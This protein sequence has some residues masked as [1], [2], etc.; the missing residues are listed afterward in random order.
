M[1]HKEEGRKPA[2]GALRQGGAGASFLWGC[3]A[4]GGRW[5]GVPPMRGGA[6]CAGSAARY[7]Y[8]PSTSEYKNK[9]HPSPHTGTCQKKDRFPRKNKILKLWV[10]RCGSKSTSSLTIG[11]RA[12]R[13]KTQ[14]PQYKRSATAGRFFI[15]F[16]SSTIEQPPCKR[17]V[18]GANPTGSSKADD[19]GNISCRDAG[20]EFPVRQPPCAY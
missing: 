17:Q 11:I 20:Q 15:C 5:G 4:A 16:Y 7:E 18:V 12:V 2:G 6:G 9:I 14:R 1:Q 10:S 3:S 13:F 8:V 19:T